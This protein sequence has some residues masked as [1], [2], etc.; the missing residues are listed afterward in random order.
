MASDWTADGNITGGDSTGTFAIGR[1]IY[2]W[3]KFTTTGSSSLTVTKDVTATV[4]IAGGGGGAGLAFS[5]SGGGGGGGAVWED[6]YDLTA[7]TGTYSVTVGTAGGTGRAQNGGTS[8]F[9]QVWCYGGGYGGTDGADADGGAGGSGGGGG[10]RDASNAG[11][12]ATGGSL[13]GGSTS[14]TTGFHCYA[15]AAG[16]YHLRGGGGGGAGATPSNGDGGAGWTS[17]IAGS[18][19]SYAGGGAEYQEVS[20]TTPGSGGESIFN[21]YGDGQTGIVIV[22]YYITPPPLY[23]RQRQ[24]PVRA[25]SRIGLVDL[26]QRQTPLINK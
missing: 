17:S 15:G 4:L 3:H 14:T 21:D 10:C 12:T 25:P 2:K 16:V 5:Y 8:K 13:D 24:S 18:A 9:D 11:G 20:Y 1:R 23:L 26:R 6:A 7:A 22:G 19:V